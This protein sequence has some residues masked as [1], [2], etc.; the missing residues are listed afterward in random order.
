MK[1]MSKNFYRFRQ[2]VCNIFRKRIFKDQLCY[3][4]N[5][6]LVKEEQETS[7][8]MHVGLGFLYDNNVERFVHH[9]QHETEGLGGEELG[10]MNNFVTLE[11]TE[12]TLVYISS[13]GKYQYV[14]GFPRKWV[15]VCSAKRNL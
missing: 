13:L 7:E 9:L 6:N 4:V 5:L 15:H 3:E 2:P 14:R 8:N 11:E 10:F 1:E 12:K